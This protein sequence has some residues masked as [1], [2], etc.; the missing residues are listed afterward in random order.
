M[1][2]QQPS[3]GMTP[4]TS[5]LSYLPARKRP[6]EQ[7]ATEFISMH[8][9]EVYDFANYGHYVLGVSAGLINYNY[10]RPHTFPQTIGKG[11]LN[12]EQLAEE[13][14]QPQELVDADLRALDWL[15]VRAKLRPIHIDKSLRPS[16]A[17]PRTRSTVHVLWAR[18]ERSRIVLP[19]YNPGIVA[20]VS[21]L[22]RERH[23]TAKTAAAALTRAMKGVSTGVRATITPQ[24]QKRDGPLNA[25]PV[26]TDRSALLDA[27]RA[28][29]A[30][31]NDA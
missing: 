29:P 21:A 14:A 22:A 9:G 4:L 15:A 16:I 18:H 11:W 23:E 25:W 30:D 20:H 17:D 6:T 8:G 7:T 31:P 13:T 24:P 26:A 10:G 12:R 27:L 2:E 19:H 1:S 28:R 5:V 3:L